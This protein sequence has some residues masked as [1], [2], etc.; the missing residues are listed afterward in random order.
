[1]GIESYKLFCMITSSILFILFLAI[2]YLDRREDK[3]MKT[4]NEQP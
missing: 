3:R 1:M 4:K 2:E